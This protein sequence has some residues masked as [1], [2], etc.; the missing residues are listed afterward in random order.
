MNDF[1]N[2]SL[3][4]NTNLLAKIEINTLESIEDFMKVR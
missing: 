3:I 1:P 4:W 2:N